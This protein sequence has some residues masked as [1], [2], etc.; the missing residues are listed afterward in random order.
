M[1]QEL[2]EGPKRPAPFET[3]KRPVTDEYHGVSVVDDYRWLEDF[4]NLEVKDWSTNQNARAR[5]IL[6]AIPI[7]ELIRER[8]AALYKSS[9]SDYLDIKYRQGRFFA[10]KFQPPKQQRLLVTLTAVDDT[11]SERVI[12]DPNRL[13]RQGLV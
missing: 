3:P 4:S 13:D 1:M 7:R 10:L 8:V 9:S 11:S 5:S 2:V 12:L 6:D